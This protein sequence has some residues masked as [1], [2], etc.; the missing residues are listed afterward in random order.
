MLFDSS[1]LERTQGVQPSGGAPDRRLRILYYT[2][3]PADVA[4]LFDPKDPAALRIERGAPKIVD[5]DR[6]RDGT[7][8]KSPELIWLARQ[9]PGSVEALLDREYIH[10][11]I[12]D[13]RFGNDVATDFPGFL[14]SAR[15]LLQRLEADEQPETRYSFH[16]ILTLVSA[17]DPDQEDR[18]IAEMGAR[19]V[20][21]VLRHRRDVSAAKF[22]TRVL[23]EIDSML[24]DR[25]KGKVALCA[26]GG[27]TTGVFFELG[28]LKCLEDCFANRTANDFDMYFGI[29]AGAV[30]TSVLASGY[31]VLDLMG[32][33]AGEAVGELPPIDLRLLQV[34]HLNYRDI[35]Q[36]ASHAL[37]LLARD[38]ASCATGQ[39]WPTFDRFLLTY[40]DIVGAPF[41]SDSFEE[42]LRDVLDRPG[43]TNDFRDLERALFI[44]GTDHDAREHVLFGSEG[45]DHVPISKAVQASFSFNPV[46]SPVE[47]EGREYVDGA[48]TRTSEF[49]EAIHRGA[50]LLFVLD[51]FVPHVA[52]PGSPGHRPG[53]LYNIEQDLRTISFT[54]FENTRHWVLRQFPEVSCYTFLPSNTLRG[55]MGSNPMDSRPFLQIWKGAYL[56][57]FQRIR[58]VEHRLRGDLAAHG[59]VLDTS[60]AEEIVARLQHVSQDLCIYDFMQEEDGPSARSRSQGKTANSDA[61]LSRATA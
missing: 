36:R 25:E 33:I 3:R 21:R 12:V 46:F 52:K 30:V 24:H 23:E 38:I 14:D 5:L 45:N 15:A 51:P 41:R 17:P 18:L 34:R 53:I 42:A 7:R 27:G 9:D 60:P 58:Q 31:R 39:A 35:V 47:I 61:P 57:T 40:S 19:R 20:G 22:R 32:S 2:P 56:S 26:S 16:R 6:R 8:A 11:V 55:M 48:I 49:V 4:R 29:S 44:G 59:I 13:L 54:R 37:K 43:R 50:D 28:V 10:L 1:D